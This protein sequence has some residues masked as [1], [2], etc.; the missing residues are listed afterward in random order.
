VT[1]LLIRGLP[2]LLAALAVGLALPACS[3]A[4]SSAP[5][6][7][8][9]AA[10]PAGPPA[11]PRFRD[12]TREAGVA[13]RH[14]S[15]AS[16]QKYLVEIVG[17][18]VGIFDYDNDGWQ[19]LLFVNGRPLTGKGGSSPTLHLFRNLGRKPLR[20][21]DVTAKAGL[22]VSLYGMACAVADYDGDGWQDVYVSAVLGP[23][24]LFRNRGGKFEDATQRAGVGN[25]G[26]WGCG[27]AWLDY[28][29]DGKLDLYVGNYVRY[30]SLADDVPCY[31][32][33]GKRSY[34]VPVAY[35]GSRGSLFHN[36]AG[37]KFVEVGAKL[38]LNDPD[39]KAL[40]VISADMNDDGWPDLVVANDTV[41]NRCFINHQGRFQEEAVESGLAFGPNGKAR[42]GM[43]VDTADWRNDGTQTVAFTFF[44]RESIGFYVQDRPGSMS[45]E[46]QSFPAG[47]GE[48]SAPLL[49]FGIRFLDWNSDGFEDLCAVHG[50]IRD[51]IAEL[52]PGQSFPQP[53][54]LFRNE[55]GKTFK[56]VSADAGAPITTRAVRRSL[57]TGDLDND[58]RPDLVTTVNNG[59]AEVWLN[60]TERAGHW[61]AV[62]LQG[63]SP[64]RDALGARVTLRAGG[65][66]QTKWLR[67]GGYLS[68]ND[69]R[70]HFGLGAAARADE[71]IVRWP[72]G[73]EERLAGADADRLL[74]LVEGKVR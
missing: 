62:R 54:L 46:D 64:N 66:T 65:R 49:G 60:E 68:E 38:G 30:R 67:S 51:D 69:R 50:H 3:P 8:G 47:I 61:L 35:R 24:R 11:E 28:D 4:R 10:V 7:D 57:A 39:Q 58:G 41:P 74:T 21:E 13:F 6:G 9:T 15:G 12:V 31:V 23:G 44:A 17:P 19:D 37:G 42:A 63:R 26:M 27:S 53:A 43:G 45:F 36:V 71:I 40:G 73:Q 1:T 20:F 25:E 34:C 14:T 55:G 18:G 48:P 72:K 52:E 56:D 59:P 22:A 32:R 33:G 29:R 16:S 5:P 70:L 2:A